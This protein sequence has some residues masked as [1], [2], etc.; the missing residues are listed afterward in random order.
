MKNILSL[1][2]KYRLHTL[3]SLI[4]GAIW[5]MSALFLPKLMADMINIGVA[6]GDIAYILRRGG[7]ML[8]MTLVNVVSLLI[9][10]Y[11]V[12]IIS[13]GIS[14]RLR[15]Q[16][17]KKVLS[18]SKSEMN[19]YG[20]ST[21]MT[22]NISDTLQVQTLVDLTF[23]KVYTLIITI[24]GAGVMAFLMDQ[25][26]AAMIFLIIPLALVI[27]LGLT[28]LALPKYQ[29]LRLSLDRINRL[30]REN[31]TGS[32]VIRA[33]NKEA[34][35]KE[36][37]QAADQDLMQ[38]NIEADR[39]MMLVAPLVL[40]MTNY[41]IIAVVYVGA[42]RIA[43]DLLKLGSLIATIE[44]VFIA[45]QNISALASI[46]SMLPRAGVAL[47]RISEVL[48]QEPS[49]L[50]GQ[51]DL[52]RT[53]ESADRSIQVDHLT[54]AFSDASS[55]QISDVSFSL[56]MGETTAIIGSTG[57][58]M[59]TL[60]RLLLRL[61]DYQ[62]GTVTVGGRDLKTL[63]N[64]AVRKIFTYVP[65][66]TFLFKGTV[67]DNLRLANPEA[68]EAVMWEALEIAQMADFLKDR[69]GLLTPIAQAGTNLSGGQRQRLAIAR[70][71]VRDTDFYIFD[72]SF[73][74][75][76]A[77]TEVRVMAAFKV[78]LAGKGILL[79]AQKIA[80]V[81]D[82]QQILVMDR[83]R[84]VAQGVHQDLAKTSSVYR[85]IMASQARQEVAS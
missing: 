17:F 28:K 33:F 49:V 75:L 38:Y 72:D 73:S 16:T 26:L 19:H 22:R 31:L 30:F 63:T 13:A 64:E 15:L 39:T 74:A 37:F 70:A 20:P 48:D 71:L 66:E 60:A 56:K 5:S 29:K 65:Q 35:E 21:L 10:C 52:D 25:K 8:A 32:R 40:L 46:I 27:I 6:S 23:R 7:F 47:G 58:G 55:K 54:F 1:A 18:F 62:N 45:L 53:W 57:S 81:K 9:N 24:F 68:S 82:A 84:I 4:M 34:F 2:K 69:Q 42:N 14:K 83:G 41:L 77:K 85:E 36:G 44:Y 78:K 76:D 79:I 80:S 59:S 3:G 50:Y 51:K 43:L 67:E 11:H 12:V 61:H